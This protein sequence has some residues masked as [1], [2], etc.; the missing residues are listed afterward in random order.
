[1]IRV[2]HF[3]DV[4]VQEPLSTVPS[5]ELWTKRILAA[6]NL[7]LTRGR[8]F[9]EVPEKLAALGRFAQAEAVDLALCSGD[10]TAIGTHAELKSARAAIKPLTTL[11]YGYLTVPGNH[12]LYA[13][14]ARDGRFEKYFGDLQPSDAPEYAVDAAYPF[15]RLIG[16]ELAVVGVNSARPNSVLSSAGRIPDAQIEALGRVLDDARL[17]GRFV[18]VMSH[19]G[20]LRRG[21]E[22]DGAHHGLENAAALMRVCDRPRVLYIHGHIHHHYCHAAAVGHPWLFCAGSATHKG[23]EGAWL[24]E[25]ERDTAHA[26]PVRW[27]EGAYELDRS[28]TV[29]VT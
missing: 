7:W 5:A 12:D 20:I 9:R 25:I 8:L 6:L 14:D 18:I 15:V 1:V 26:V 2:L 13:H 17:A 23:R 22:P 10:Y 21:G 27:R 29:Q 16:S 3:S 11:A 4:H 19:Y 28:A 24:Y